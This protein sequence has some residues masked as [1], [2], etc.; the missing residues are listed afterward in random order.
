MVAAPDCDLQRGP[1]TAPLPGG[2]RIEFGIT[3]RPIPVLQ[4]LQLQ[5][6]LDGIAARVVIVEFTGADM[7]MGINRVAMKAEGSGRFS[8]SAMLPVCVRNRMA[9]LATVRLQTN[10]GQIAVPFHFETVRN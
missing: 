7:D 1:C 3:P 5:A 4:P 9:W 2:G 6:R 10:Q 8:G